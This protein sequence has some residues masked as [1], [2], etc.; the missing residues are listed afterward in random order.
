MYCS[1]C[2]QELPDIAR[3]CFMCGERVEDQNISSEPENNGADETSGFAVENEKLKAYYGKSVN[4]VIPDTVKSIEDSVF[5]DKDIRS[6]VIPD[7][8]ERIE[9]NAFY[10]TQIRELSIPASVSFIG[11]H[12]FE[13]NRQLVRIVFEGAP[14][15]EMGAFTGCDGLK[16]IV[17]NDAGFQD[18]YYTFRSCPEDIQFSGPDS[19]KTLILKFY[20]E[21][22]R[23]QW[24]LEHK[25]SYCGGNFVGNLVKKCAVCGQIK[26]YQD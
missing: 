25:C 26:D 9:K 5:M 23:L 18:L 13:N 7:G 24:I 1:N 12:A 14:T 19:T 8:V 6:V 20:A 15:I 10:H 21:R 3:Y 17:I 2:G 16:E 11:A 4:I 22:Q